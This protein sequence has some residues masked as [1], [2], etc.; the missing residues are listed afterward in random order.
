MKAVN[1]FMYKS[2]TIL[3]AFVNFHNQYLMKFTERMAVEEW[4]G[5]AENHAPG[6][7]EHEQF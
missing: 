1:K 2:S 3:F 7:L 4:P 6:R 5:L